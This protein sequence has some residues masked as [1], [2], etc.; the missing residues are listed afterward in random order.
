MPAW[1]FPVE[2]A[3]V[4]GRPAGVRTE[5][6]ADAAGEFFSG[7]FALFHMSPTR[8]AQTEGL[9]IGHNSVKNEKIH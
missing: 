6:C 1:V 8:G 7:R 2:A 3:G 9:L 4:E 5:C